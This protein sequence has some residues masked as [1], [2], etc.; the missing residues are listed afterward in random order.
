VTLFTEEDIQKYAFPAVIDDGRRCFARGRV[1]KVC[2]IGNDIIA[3]VKNDQT[4]KVV[5]SRETNQLRFDCTCGFSY[6]GA[7]EHVVAVMLAA[8]AHQAIQIGIDWDSDVSNDSPAENSSFTST[9]PAASEPDHEISDDYVD[10]ASDNSLPV[11]DVP[12]GKPIGRLYLSE[13][14]SMLFVEVRFVYHDGTVEFNRVDTA[15]SRLVPSGDGNVYRVTRSKARE[16]SMTATLAEFELM[17]YQTGFYTPTCDPRMW[18][19]HELPR[20]SQEGFEVYGQ[21]KLKTTD[22]RKSLPKLS[23]NITSGSSVFDCTV[24]VSFDG[25]TAT[26]AALIIAVRQGSRFILLSDGSSGLIPQEW[27]EKFAGLFAA[28]DADPSQASLKIKPSHLSLA[29]MLYDMADERHGDDVFL[30]RRDDLQK[31]SGVEHHELPVE[32]Q[33]SMRQYQLAGYEWFYFL[34]KYHLG[35]CLADDMGLG[36]TVQTLAL[37]LKEKQL[38]EQTQPSLIILPTSLIFNWQR[39]AQKFTPTLNLLIYHGAGRQQYIDILHMSDVVLTSYGTVLRDIDILK[40]KQFHYIILDEAQAIKNPSSQVTHAIR[41]LQG[42]FRLALSGTPIE[43]NLAELWSLFSF[44]NPGMLG[45][46][47]NF[48]QNFVKPIEREL[49]ES[50]AEVLRKLIFPFMLRRTKQQVAKDLPSKSEITIYAEMLP[51]Q[52]TIYEITRETYRGKIVDSLDNKGMDKSRFQILEG[53]LRLRQ[54]CSHPKLVDPS[55]TGDSGKFQIVVESIENLVSEGHR[56][57]IFSQFVKSLELLRE[58][59]AEIGIT[60]EILTG[61]TRDRQGVV[62]R[63]QKKNGAPVFLISLKAGGTGLNLTSADYVIHIDPWWNPSAENQASD[64]AYRIG[65]TRNVF[66]YKMITK[67]SI[68]ERIAA[69]QERKKNL[70]ESVIQTEN[71]FFKQ[72]TRNDIVGLFS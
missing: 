35:G 39:E 65:Q 62:D 14:D 16:S 56:V 53:L 67:D 59:F 66:V 30:S 45:T 61:A 38:A 71:N 57:L 6:A 46:Y 42:S 13:S 2:F 4:Y 36:K 31:F 60:C 28:L 1:S 64:R 70:M 48:A 12:P 15:L 54:I 11:V 26:L 20:L 22:A 51:K 40:E 17:R 21:E 18:T 49:N 41:Q 55:F 68:E 69:L 32:F 9:H 29:G 58:R 72:L 8:N 7:C 27:I 10:D 37:L 43:N 52:K 23:V 5:I 3:S 33:A 44:I 50:A 19:L 24:S 25:I 47:R 34:K 63:F